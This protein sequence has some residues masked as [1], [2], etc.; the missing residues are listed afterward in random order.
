MRA[1]WFASI[2]RHL[3]SSSRPAFA[4][5]P[6]PHR[7]LRSVA[8][9]V[10]PSIRK[11]VI[12]DFISAALRDR[13]PVLGFHT[14]S[15]LLPATQSRFYAVKD[16]SR[17]PRTPVTSK[18]KKYKIKSYSSFKFRFRT[19]NDGRIR[20]WKAGKRHNAHLKSKEAKRRLRRPGIVHAAYAKVM[21]KLNFCA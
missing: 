17:A 4:P 3:L 2:G 14:P 19:M 18:V 6:F 12:S 11:P 9:P 10:D 16:R 5:A 20:R 1:R 7:C 13:P 21:K 8:L 15:P